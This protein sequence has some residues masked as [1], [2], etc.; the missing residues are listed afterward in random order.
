[1]Y[2]QELNW[3]RQNRRSTGGQD[4]A[5]YRRCPEGHWHS[6]LVYCIIIIIVIIVIII[7]Y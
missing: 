6:L 1:M 7:I 2:S 5:G 4:D 3:K